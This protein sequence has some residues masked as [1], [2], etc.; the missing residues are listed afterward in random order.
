[1]KG[2]W[3]E[4]ED[5]KVVELVMKHGARKWSMIASHLAT[6][7]G[8]QCRERWH[9]HLNPDI[10]KSPW[11]E[12]EDRTI[13]LEHVRVG[14]RWAEIASKLPGR[15]DN[16][17]KNHWNSSMKRRVHKFLIEKTN[18]VNRDKELTLREFFCLKDD[19][20]DNENDI[21]EACLRAARTKVYS[22]DDSCSWSGSP[23]K[24]DSGPLLQKPDNVPPSVPAVSES[25]QSQ[26]EDSSSASS[27]KRGRTVTPPNEEDEPTAQR[28]SVATVD[29]GEYRRRRRRDDDDEDEN[30]EKLPMLPP[31]GS[32]VD[33]KKISLALTNSTCGG[34]PRRAPRIS[35]GPSP[36]RPE[37]GIDALV[38]VLDGSPVKKKKNKRP[39]VMTKA[40]IRREEEARRLR[41][42]IRVLSEQS[43]SK[44]YQHRESPRKP[45]RSTPR[46]QTRRELEASP[47]SSLAVA[48]T[49]SPLELDKLLTD[50]PLRDL[51]HK[52]II[53]KTPEH[54][55][56]GH[57]PVGNLDFSPLFKMP[58]L[59]DRS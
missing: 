57:P 11:T 26:E 8:K 59:D 56:L 52:N 16:A 32:P 27:T 53:A 7:T 2:A 33:R 4:D 43:P 41:K 50:S 55:H 20:Q 38:R 13:L 18:V 31:P 47:L 30:E 10:C 44:L 14:N 28:V 25:S 45:P 6:R 49:A 46:R 42:A 5:E 9:N 19:D 23:V 34:T 29:C 24:P 22:D 15:T 51:M 36:K 17:I 48:A 1:M 12:E 37:D 39:I 40:E 21:V 58:H 54:G 3:R 35:P